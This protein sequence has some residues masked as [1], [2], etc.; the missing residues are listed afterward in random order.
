[1]NVRDVVSPDVI[2]VTPASGAGSVE[3]N[4]QI[5]VRFSEAVDRSSVTSASI[6]LTTNSAA[7]PFTIGFT[8]GDQTVT[9]TPV[10]LLKLNTN[11]TIDASTQIR[12]VNGNA[13]FASRTSVFKTKSPDT[14]PPR[15]VAIAPA[16]NAVNVP[17][18]T[19]VRVSFTEPVDRTT[20]TPASFRVTIGGLQIPGPVQL[21]R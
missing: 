1:M 6:R 21:P 15:V 4:V 19:D 14:V 8:D 13:L 10:D 20:I 3:P 11:Y 16:N 5:V 9:L 7:V 12:D 18:G 2:L 17:V